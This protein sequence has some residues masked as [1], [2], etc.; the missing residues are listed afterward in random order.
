MYI[1]KTTNLLNGKIYI[2]LTRKSVDESQNYY[3]SGW[4]L[5]NAI[6]K[7]GK[8][9]FVK[10]II[11]YCTSLEALAIAEKYW[12]K[13]LNATNQNIGYNLHPG[14]Q[15]I[16]DYSTCGTWER[17]DE[18]RAKMSRVKSG[19]KQTPE[20]ITARSKALTGRKRSE[21]TKAKIANTLKGKNHSEE[22]IEKVRKSLTGRKNGP[23]SKET[24]AKI[25]KANKGKKW[26]YNPETL[27]K[28]QLNPG[29]DVPTGFIKGMG[30]RPD[31]FK[32][33]MRKS[34]IKRKVL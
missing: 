16:Y 18:F 28:I 32:E 2:G 26:Y 29:D 25:A 6:K 19:I 24:K 1:Y 21:V 23:H 11:Q 31:S 17:T 4:K 34:W 10:E 13:R 9:N 12:I 14:G 15:L 22:R 3:G 7:H 8:E 20:A 5:K 27:Y 33:T 30:P